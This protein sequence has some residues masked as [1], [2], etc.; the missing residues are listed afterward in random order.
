[1][2]PILLIVIN[3]SSGCKDTI[4]KTI[5][6]TDNTNVYIPNAFYPNTDGLNDYFFPISRN[7]D[8]ITM[9]IFNRWGELLFETN[10]FSPGWDGKYQDHICPQD[11]YMYAIVLRN[12]GNNKVKY[13]SGTLTLLR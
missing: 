11:V 9:R 1:M 12:S 10:H 13:F 6:I 2:K 3:K 5:Q 4:I 8:E 7:Y